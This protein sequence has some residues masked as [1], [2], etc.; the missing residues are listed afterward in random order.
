MIGNYFLDS[1]L[2]ST[3]INE[4]WSHQIINDTLPHEDFNTLR[5]EC[6]RLSVPNDK[7]VIIYP[8][9]FND[10]N[11]SFYDQIHDISKSIIDNAKQLCDKYSE[12]RWFKDLAVNAHISVTPPLPYKFYIHQEGLEKIWSSVTYVTPENNVGTKMYTE[13]KEDTFVKEAEWKPNSTFIF[14]GQQGK[15]WHSYESDQT[16]QR[17]TLNLFLMKDNNKCFYRD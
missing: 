11:I 3:V 15:T 2:N 12:H 10:Y 8:K 9:D 17:I 13:Q 5:K 6:E 7:L 14:C 1:C 16:K 4:P